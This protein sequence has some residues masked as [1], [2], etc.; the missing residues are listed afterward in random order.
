[1]TLP[2]REITPL[3]LTFNEEDN[4]ER[5]LAPLSWARDIVVVGSGSTDRALRI[6]ARDPRIRVIHRN[7]DTHATQWN[8]SL[9]HV[10]T[11]WVL[12]VD[13][14]YESSREFASEI[15]R[16][17]PPEAI[18]AQGAAPLGRRRRYFLLN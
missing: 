16:L 17:D 8:F 13:A 6:L 18:T 5:T 15:A 4:L 12:S 1:M 7:F 9:K 14:D 10:A 3:L 2:A 11:D